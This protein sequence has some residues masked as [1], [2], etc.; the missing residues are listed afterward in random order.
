V[1]KKKPATAPQPG[2]IE[3]AAQMTIAQAAE[4]HVAFK[5]RMGG[6]VVID[7][8][9]VEQIDT[10]ILQLLVSFWHTCKQRGITADWLGVSAGLRNAANLI[11]V[12]EFLHF[13]GAEAAGTVRTGA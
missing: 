4:L 10:A 2:K 7:G 13:P 9:R 3:L 12:A 8:S 1:K 11:G 6:A 5:E